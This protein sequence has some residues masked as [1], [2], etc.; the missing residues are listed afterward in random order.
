LENL[1]IPL[2]ADPV[3]LEVTRGVN[4]TE[5]KSLT[6]APYAKTEIKDVN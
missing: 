2:E 6:K 3:P 5:T 4:Q 1:T